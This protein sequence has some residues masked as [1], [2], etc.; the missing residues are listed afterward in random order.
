MALGVTQPL[1]KMS[2]RNIP[3]GKGGRCVK[4]TSPTSRAECHE[5]WEPKPSGTLWATPGLLRDSFT[6]T[7]IYTVLHTYRTIK[8]RLIDSKFVC[9]QMHSL[10]KYKM[11]QLTLEISLYMASTCF[12][13]L[14]PSLGSIRQ[15]LAKVTVSVTTHRTAPSTHTTDWSTYCHC[16]A[17]ILT[18]CFDV[19]TSIVSFIWAPSTRGGVAYGVRTL[20]TNRTSY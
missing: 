4:L 15:N 7:F 16:T 3:G 20:P 10:L 1:V 11:L 9:Q 18:M 14:G 8:K 13:P 12:G 19:L 6:F 17:T 5:I 2:T